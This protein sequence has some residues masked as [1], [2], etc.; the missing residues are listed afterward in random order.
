MGEDGELM[1]LKTLF[2]ES[3]PMKNTTIQFG[4]D[5]KVRSSFLSKPET[6][7]KQWAAPIISDKIETY[8]L[9]LTTIL[10]SLINSISRFYDKKYLNLP[11]IVSLMIVLQ[12]LTDLFDGEVG[13][14]RNTGLIKW[15]F[16][17]SSIYCFQQRLPSVSQALPSTLIRFK[18]NCGTMTCRPRASLTGK[19]QF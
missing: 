7:F 13:R 4:G 16:Y 5:K 10:W 18:K 19:V 14:Q 3:E 8:H 6:R 9:T 15:G 1:I 2:I 12:Y 11:W 17:A